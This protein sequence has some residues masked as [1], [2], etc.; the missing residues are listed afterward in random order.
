MNKI[1]LSI[2]FGALLIATPALAGQLDN[3]DT[4]YA[5]RGECESANAGFSNEVR[6]SLLQDFPNFFDSEGDVASFLTRAFTCE[7]SESDGQWYIHDHR[8]DV[9]NSDWYQRR[10]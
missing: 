2:A 7:L 6:D 8:F 5:S 4:P 3:L 10:H 1:R 9:I